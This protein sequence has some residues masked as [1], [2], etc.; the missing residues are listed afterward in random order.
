[1]SFDSQLQRC[2]RAINHGLFL[3]HS[4]NPVGR[5]ASFSIA[6]ELMEEKL[7]GPAKHEHSLFSEKEE[8]APRSSK[9]EEKMQELLISASMLQALSECR[10]L[11]NPLAASELMLEIRKMYLGESRIGE[12]EKMQAR[13]KSLLERDLF[14]D[15]EAALPSCMPVL[16]FIEE[17]NQNSSMR[18]N[19]GLESIGFLLGGEM[20]HDFLLRFG[21]MRQAANYLNVSRV[22]RLGRLQEAME[23]QEGALFLLKT[24]LVENPALFMAALG[25]ANARGIFLYSAQKNRS[26]KLLNMQSLEGDFHAPIGSLENGM[27]TAC[28]SSTLLTDDPLHVPII[29][30]ELIRAQQHFADVRRNPGREPEAFVLFLDSASGGSLTLCDP[31]QKTALMRGAIDASELKKKA[32]MN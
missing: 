19:F 31:S 9:A 29:F 23:K 4:H 27:L 10:C 1:M 21:S 2:A 3:N 30:E 15:V 17:I 5:R 24:H 16:K 32:P 14:R 13:V 25:A 6:F 7:A 28:F 18:V 8:P 20:E 12:M 26:A 11:R 22:E